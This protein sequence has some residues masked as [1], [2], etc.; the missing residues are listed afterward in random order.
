MQNGDQFV[1]LPR[2]TCI[3]FLEKMQVK[4]KIEL[5]VSNKVIKQLV[6]ELHQLNPS[7]AVLPELV[8]KYLEERDALNGESDESD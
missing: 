7:R 3:G 4:S 5:D 1:K 6:R 2:V 8:V